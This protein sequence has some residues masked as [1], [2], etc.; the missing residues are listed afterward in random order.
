MKNND[1]GEDFTEILPFVEV[2]RLGFETFFFYLTLSLC[3][4]K[5]SIFVREGSLSRCNTASVTQLTISHVAESNS[6]PR[7]KGTKNL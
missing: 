2:I 7:Y 1:K 3:L 6:F 4:P 5:T